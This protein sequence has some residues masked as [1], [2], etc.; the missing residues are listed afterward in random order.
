MGMYIATA[1]PFCTPT[2]FNQLACNE[3]PL[4]TSRMLQHNHCHA[5]QSEC[6]RVF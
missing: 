6:W 3:I 5:L 2:D 4:S 1:S